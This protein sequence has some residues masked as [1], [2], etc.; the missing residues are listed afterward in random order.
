MDSDNTVLLIWKIYFW[1]HHELAGLVLSCDMGAGLKSGG[2]VH[3]GGRNWT[4]CKKNSR[5]VR[6]ICR[7]ENLYAYDSL[8]QTFS[9]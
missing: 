2:S 4:Y 8:F 9:C 7:L 6:S 1:R 5:N 3:S